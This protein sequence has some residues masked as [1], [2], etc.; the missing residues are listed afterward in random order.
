ME[1]L[2]IRI[3]DIDFNRN[4]IYIPQAKSGARDQPIPSALADFLKRYIYYF[5]LYI[6]LV[7]IVN[8]RFFVDKSVNT[9]KIINLRV[10]KQLA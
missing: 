4:V 10:T 3:E 8:D 5:F 2:S 6:K 7:V 1:I 9:L